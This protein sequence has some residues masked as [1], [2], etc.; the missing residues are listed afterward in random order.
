M[1]IHQQRITLKSLK[2]ADFASEETLCFTAIVLFDGE[3]VADASNDGHGGMT[4]V[5]SRDGK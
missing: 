3:P 1:T 2:V 5:R 4:F